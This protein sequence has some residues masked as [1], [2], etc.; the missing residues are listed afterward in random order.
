MKILLAVCCKPDQARFVDF[1]QMLQDIEVPE[2]CES[3]IELFPGWFS[4]ENKNN[5]IKMAMAEGFHYIFF[6]DDDQI[7]PPHTLKQLLAHNL[8][9]VT[10]N[11]LWRR[12]PFNPFL[13]ENANEKGQA[14]PMVLEDLKPG[15]IEVDAC[16][17]GGILIKTEVFRNM[18]FPWWAIDENLKTEDL[19]FCREA[20]KLG[21]KV[22][23]DLRALS[24]HMIQAVVWPAYEN[25]KWITRIS[26]MNSITFDCPAASYKETGLTIQGKV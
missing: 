6:L 19:Y 11:L 7:I 14:K 12:P 23:C 25:G 18:Q 24:G 15:L 26:I 4:Y 16:G 1:Y 2:G 5:A 9:I 13:F 20:K 17:A 21:Y 3:K 10:V 8:D 22:F